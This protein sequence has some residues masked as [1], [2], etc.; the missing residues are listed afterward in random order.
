VE[1]PDTAPMKENIGIFDIETTG[2]KANWSHMLSWCMKE[3]GK[4]MIHSDLITSREARDKND[5]RIVKSAVAEIKKYD[6]ICGYY[7]TRFD[8]PYLRSRALSQ[9]VDFPSYRD[10][11][12]T[13]LYYIARAKF[14]IHSNRLGAVCEFFGIEAKGHRMTP[15][16]W[17][18]AGAGKQEA[19]ETILIHC[20]E[21]VES[22]DKVFSL[23]LDHM[24]VNKRS[25]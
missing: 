12:H 22:T 25:I 14:A 6:R 16:L 19:L 10:L 18:D 2:L 3:H 4:D 5:Y 15:N 24:L 20:K 23:L 7:S 17:K 21:D 11:Y 9:G 8:I 13:D 1:K